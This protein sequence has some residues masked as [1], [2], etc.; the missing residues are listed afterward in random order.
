MPTKTSEIKKFIKVWNIDKEEYKK[1]L[2]Q[3]I[4]LADYRS[5]PYLNKMYL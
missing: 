5:R 2:E 4:A 1:G 3:R